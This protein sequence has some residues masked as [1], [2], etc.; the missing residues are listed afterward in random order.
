M[1]DVATSSTLAL[2]IKEFGRN[3]DDLALSTSTCRREGVKVV[4]KEA[5]NPNQA[6]G[7]G[8]Y[9]PQIFKRLFLCN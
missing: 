5:L 1:S 4:T 8:K 9:A 6:G 3:L 2:V 7:G